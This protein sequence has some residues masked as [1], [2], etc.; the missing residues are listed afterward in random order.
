MLCN[1]TSPSAG[2]IAAA[3]TDEIF[4]PFPEPAKIE[5]VA[6]SEEQLKKYA[7]IWKNDVTRSANQIVLD[8]GELKLNGGALKPVADGS[9]MLGERKVRFKDGSINTGQ[10]A[11]PD[12]S[13]TKLTQVSEWKPAAADLSA[14]MGDWYSEEAQ[15]GVKLVLEGDKAFIVIRPVA[16]LP[17]MP[18]YKDHFAA[19][20]YVVW[21]TRDS[22]G[23]IDQMHVGT[24]RMRDMLFVRQLK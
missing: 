3:I 6:V 4:G 2:G 23:K 15:S 10:I 18:I 22:A 7:G 24:G 9:F 11:N 8:K 1:G 21:F 5:G 17:M 16:K 19:Q 14:F 13:V 12:G 20:G